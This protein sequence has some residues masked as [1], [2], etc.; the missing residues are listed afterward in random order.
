MTGL[1]ERHEDEKFRPLTSLEH[2]LIEAKAKLV[3][4][5][6]QG[7]LIERLAYMDELEEQ[8]KMTSEALH[9]EEGRSE[10]LA[11]QLE[12]AGGAKKISSTGKVEETMTTERFNA[13]KVRCLPPA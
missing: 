7:D 2:E 9:H 13:M 5:E 8:L 4:Y 1:N 12:D 3:Q 10:L 11:Q 6:G